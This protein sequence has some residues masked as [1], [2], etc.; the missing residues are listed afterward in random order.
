MNRKEPTDDEKYF[1][2][3]YVLEGVVAGESKKELSSRRRWLSERLNYSPSVIAAVSAHLKIRA[4]DLVGENLSR[5]D[6]DDARNYVAEAK[7]EERRAKQFEISEMFGI[8]SEQAALIT[9][10]VLPPIPQSRRTISGEH[11][12][13]DNETKNNWRRSWGD[14]LQERTTAD[15]RKDMRVLCFPGVE[16]HEASMYLDMD[17]Q[18]ENIVGVEGGNKLA[19][20]QFEKNA[21]RLG[22]DYRLGKMEK[23]LPA[24]SDRFD[25]VNLDF[26]GHMCARN[27]AILN[28]LL[29][30]QT[31]YLSVNIAGRRERKAMQEYLQY[32]KAMTSRSIET[33]RGTWEQKLARI[34]DPF[35]TDE[36]L[37][38][39]VWREQFCHVIPDAVGYTR[40]E[41][42][43]LASVSC[44]FHEDHDVREEAFRN[45][46]VKIASSLKSHKHTE[47]VALATA[48][49][50]IET[51]RSAFFSSSYTSELQP[52]QY[53]STNGAPFYSHFYQLDTPFEDYYNCR[54]LTE[55]IAKCARHEVDTKEGRE[56]SKSKFIYKDKRYCPI[57]PG[58]KLNRSDDLCYVADDKMLAHIS[59][60]HLLKSYQKIE[61]M[62]KHAEKVLNEA[63]ADSEEPQAAAK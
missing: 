14:F 57:P 32:Y 38:G 54:R 6:I 34:Q 33:E 28:N 11:F 10:G 7:D 21:S 16:C 4:Y 13:Y 1:I 18:P 44:S 51:A 26:T 37:D 19:Q 59:L 25:V 45:L 63:I 47:Q 46:T 27:V 2:C 48:H 60:R 35:S 17:F 29:V 39:D 24:D 58:G 61:I 56:D 55:F 42:R 49:L 12:N 31:A 5:D 50:I 22:I 15:Q 9:D 62:K 30:N 40:A 3:E 20:A 8:S 23:I 36:D 53:T 52:D 41:N 43:R